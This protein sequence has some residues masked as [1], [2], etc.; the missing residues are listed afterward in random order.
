MH[1]LVEKN[2]GVKSS[3]SNTS[4]EKAGGK[5][6]EDKLNITNQADIL[7]SVT[8]IPDGKTLETLNKNLILVGTFNPYENS[9][10]LI[11]WKKKILM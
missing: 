8:S 1:S 5:L 11:I 10:N 7:L 6:I 3:F 9:T 4:Y 2:A